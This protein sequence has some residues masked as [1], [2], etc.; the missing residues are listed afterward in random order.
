MNMKKF[1]TNKFFIHAA[2]FAAGIIIAWFYLPIIAL[3]FLGYS[4]YGTY[5]LWQKLFSYCKNK[6]TRFTVGIVLA[7]T[8]LIAAQ[9]SGAL[10]LGLSWVD[11]DRYTKTEVSPDGKITAV[12]SPKGNNKCFTVKIDGQIFYTRASIYHNTK[13]E[14][15]NNEHFVLKS[16]DVGD[17]EF[18]KDNGVWKASPEDLIRPNN[19]IK[20]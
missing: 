10:Y 13:V 16:S 17:I 11:Y 7:A 3:W 18:R 12:L 8:A 20:E 2:I 15:Q 19:A 6:I 1:L 9:L 14:W 5:K 4:F